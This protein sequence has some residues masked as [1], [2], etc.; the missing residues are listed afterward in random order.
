MLLPREELDRILNP[1]NDESYWLIELGKTHE[2]KTKRGIK[3]AYNYA[4]IG[5]IKWNWAEKKLYI[6]F[7]RRGKP[8]KNLNFL[9]EGDP[10]DIA[11]AILTAIL[12]HFD[13]TIA[14]ATPL[15][16]L[17]ISKGLLY[18]GRTSFEK[19]NK[20]KMNSDI[21]KKSK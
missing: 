21:K 11:Q 12:I 17:V 4:Q 19:S 8:K 7:F 13:T 6:L 2:S 20:K 16:G 10:R 5:K 18:L 1:R 14:I 9:I 15:T 3:P